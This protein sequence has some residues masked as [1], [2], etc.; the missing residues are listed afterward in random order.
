[1]AKR[2]APSAFS[3]STCYRT[4]APRTSTHPSRPAA[5]T[6]APPYAGAIYAVYLDRE[7]HQLSPVMSECLR[8]L[9]YIYIYIDGWMDGWSS[10]C[11]TWHT[12]HIVHRLPVPWDINDALTAIGKTTTT[13][14]TTTNTWV[15][16]TPKCTR[17]NK[18]INSCKV[19]CLHSKKYLVTKYIGFISMENI[20]TKTQYSCSAQYRDTLISF[21]EQIRW[22]RSTDR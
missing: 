9:L 13:T 8:S 15:C 18:R 19:P 22:T 1:M 5:Y 3:Y 17:I 16:H 7:R 21:E 2:Q 20:E 14:S 6:W 4:L 11:C 12:G 10:L